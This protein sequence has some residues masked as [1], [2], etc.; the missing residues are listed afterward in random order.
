MC[1]YVGHLYEAILK[2]IMEIQFGK[3][4]GLFNIQISPSVISIIS[5]QHLFII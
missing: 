4:N 5:F 3:E 2:V 1:A